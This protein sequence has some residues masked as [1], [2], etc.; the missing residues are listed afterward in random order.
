MPPNI[1]PI[2]GAE[3][4]NLRKL[5]SIELFYIRFLRDRPGG[6]PVVGCYCI[7]H[8]CALYWVHHLRTSEP[9][10]NTVTS[11]SNPVLCEEQVDLV[12]K[13]KFPKNRP[14]GAYFYFRFTWT[15]GP[16]FSGRFSVVALTR[17]EN[18]IG[19][20]QRLILGFR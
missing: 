18:R 5:T 11:R 19:E 16:I 6:N 7:L 17:V 9:S 20:P 3:V 10:G 1:N 2:P 4:W 8:R 14:C 15:F 13:C 12:R